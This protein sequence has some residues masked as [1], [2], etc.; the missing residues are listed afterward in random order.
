[1]TEVNLNEP[2]GIAL[3]L[4][5]AI[6]EMSDRAEALGGARTIAGVAALNTLQKSL[7]KN[8]VRVQ[9]ALA[10]ATS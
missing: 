6:L 3:A 9:Q 7:Q 5:D 10:K 4:L 8:K 2:A 1:M